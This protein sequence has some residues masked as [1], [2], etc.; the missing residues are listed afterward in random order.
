M[1]SE[2]ERRPGG[3]RWT[4]RPEGWVATALVVVVS[5]ALFAIGTGLTPIW[6]VT[7]AAPVPVLLLAPR[8]SARRACG[9]AGAALLLGT[10]PLAHYWLAVL[11][12]PAPLVA[13]WL[14][15]VPW[16]FAAVAVLFRALLLRGHAALAV[17]SAAACWS[18]A[19]YLIAVLTPAGANWTLADTQADNLPVL[20]IVSVT[21]PWAVGFTL[22]APA[23]A[24]A[25]LAGP[26]PAVVRRLGGL[27]GALVLAVVLGYGLVCL[28]HAARPPAGSE[29]VST[30]GAT[31]PVSLVAVPSPQDQPDAARPAG[32]ALLDADLTWVHGLP[33]GGARLVVFPEKDVLVDPTTLP[34]LSRRFAAAAGDRHVT[35]VLGVAEHI[36]STVFN[37][38]LVFPP[39]GGVPARYR[40][41][42]PVPGVE[43]DVTPGRGIAV[44]GGA[45]PRIGVAICADL[46]QVSLGREYGRAATAVLAVPALDFGVDAW[47]QSR[48]QFL[49][50]VENG[51]SVAR[52]SRQGYLTLTD[53]QG[54]VVAQA[55]SG[56]DRVVSVSGRLPSTGGGT[57]YSRLGD[58][59]AWGCLALVAAAAAVAT[60]ARR[61]R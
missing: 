34:G 37:T 31:V 41:R 15:A 35:L 13:A 54:R 8:V 48:V 30:A 9:A 21:G 20:Q 45:G 3:R 7:W 25:A 58:W 1:A 56:G 38:A 49:R 2:A 44:S 5:A 33:D 53:P 23:A 6:W 14:L 42:Y 22:V 40:K 18:G 50:G 59:F 61:Q 28:V 32:R 16:V 52:A 47:S 24:A 27:T 29:P 17:L 4:R 36:G 57:L 19:E 46:G 10:A 11:E 26:A 43:D 55:R 60:T 39:D 12:L 51:F